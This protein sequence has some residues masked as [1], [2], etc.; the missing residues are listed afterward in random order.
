MKLNKLSILAQSILTQK[1]RYK[2]NKEIISRVFKMEHEDKIMFRL[3]VIDSYYSTQMN[4]RLY[5]LE[6]IAIALSAFKDDEELRNEANKFL[7]NPKEGKIKALFDSTY[8]F[9]K[10][11]KKSKKAISLVSKYLYFLMD[12]QFPIYDNLGLVSYKLL[13]N[14]FPTLKLNKT[15]NEANYFQL[16]IKL[17][18]VSGINCFN[19]LD[20]LLWLMGKINEGSFSI[21]MNKEKYETLVSPLHI[22]EKTKS[23]TIDDII[24]AYIRKNYRTLDFTD[25]EKVFFEF[26]FKMIKNEESDRIKRNRKST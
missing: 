12:Y 6:D 25:E 20:N 7:D 3:T 26:V 23:K 10:Q 9:D 5:G 21:L 16:M 4:K 22:P 13:A 24:R 15:I 11:A 14:K 19:T 17:N 1:T 18:Q 8:G 2:S